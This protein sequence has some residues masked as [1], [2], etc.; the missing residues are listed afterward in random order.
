MDNRD[1]ISVA[2]KMALKKEM[3]QYDI[4]AV[5]YMSMGIG[6]S[7]D[8]TSSHNSKSQNEQHTKM[9]VSVK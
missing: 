7:I 4:W 1:N 6:D 5:R 8:W 9:E 3:W 2:K